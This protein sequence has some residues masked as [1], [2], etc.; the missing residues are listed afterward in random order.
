[1]ENHFITI[2]KVPVSSYSKEFLALGLFASDGRDA[3]FKVSRHKMGI[4]KNLLSEDS[5]HLLESKMKMMKRDF[6]NSIETDSIS[7]DTSHT[8]WSQNHLEYLSKYSNNVL[9][10]DKPQAIDLALNEDVFDRLF[11]RYVSAH[12]PTKREHKTRFKTVLRNKLK[13]QID[14]RVTWDAVIDKNRVHNLIFPKITFDFA[15]VNGGLVIGHGQDFSKKYVDVR[16]ELA[17]LYSM[18]GLNG[19]ISQIFLVGKEPKKSLNDNHQLWQEFRS[20]KGIK[21]IE[22]DRTLDEIVE[23]VHAHDV[24]PLPE[25]EAIKDEPRD[26]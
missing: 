11:E 2:L 22:V 19:D 10:F 9:Q 17:T 6:K 14:D 13:P 7:F 24:T 8:L 21:Y 23:F 4:L 20:L 3:F 18:V 26:D 5:F 15:G 16:D 12:A 25:V 1:M